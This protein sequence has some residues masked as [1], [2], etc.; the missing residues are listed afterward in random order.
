MIV[1]ALAL[2]VAAGLGVLYCAIQAF[3]FLATALNPHRPAGQRRLRGAVA[4]LFGLGMFTS[5][6]AGY[7]GIV[8]LMYYA[9]T[10]QHQDVPDRR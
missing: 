2:F 8:A 6:A 1:F 9:Q 7:L 3:R 5:A 4:A 10:A